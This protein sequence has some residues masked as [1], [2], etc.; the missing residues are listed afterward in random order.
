MKRKIGIKL[1]ILTILLISMVIVK[2][3]SEDNIGLI[4]LNKNHGSN[5]ANTNHVDSDDEDEYERVIE[6]DEIQG[7]GTY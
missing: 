4:S 2:A 3:S 7:D 5:N 1:M 6:L